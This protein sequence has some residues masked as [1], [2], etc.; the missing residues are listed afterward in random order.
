MRLGASFTNNFSKYKG[1]LP[2]R[3]GTGSTT[4]VWADYGF[5]YPNYSASGFADLTFGNNFMINIRGGRF[6]Y[7]TTNQLVNSSSPRL[8]LGDHAHVVLDAPHDGRVILVDV[9][10]LAFIAQDADI[11]ERISIHYNHI[12]S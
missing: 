12:G 1:N 9:Q 7:N 6:F 8:L 5:T 4:D 2:P 11:F 3:D 10:N